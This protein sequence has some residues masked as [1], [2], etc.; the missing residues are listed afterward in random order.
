MSKL[1]NLSSELLPHDVVFEILTRLP[2]KSLIRFRCVSKSWYST[3]TDP[4]FITKHLNLNNKAKSLSSNNNHNGC[5]LYDCNK[6]LCTAVCNGN[7]NGDPKLTLTSTEV[8]RFQI[9]FSVNFYKISFCNGMF[10]NYGY[11]R[12]RMIY[13]WNPSIQKFKMFAN[14]PISFTAGLA[15]HSKNNDFKILQIA[16]HPTFVYNKKKA[17]V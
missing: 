2:V 11:L 8:S 12:D 10:L 15:Y 5:L 13:L 3:I 4:I 16:F 7:G 9:P 6:Q 1:R 17:A 14:A